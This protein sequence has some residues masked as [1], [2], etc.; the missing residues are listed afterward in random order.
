[1][2]VWENSPKFSPLSHF[3]IYQYMGNVT[4]GLGPDVRK[5]DRPE[6]V[7]SPGAA[8][9]WESMTGHV[10]YRGRSVPVGPTAAP[11]AK[12]DGSTGSGGWSPGLG[13]Y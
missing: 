11:Q 13:D 12:D 1:M 5:G 9:R 4:S 3:S 10:V 7:G 8:G 6:R 2:R